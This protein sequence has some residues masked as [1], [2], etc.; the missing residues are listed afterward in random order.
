MNNLQTLI[1][2]G[3]AVV[4][5]GLVL[6]VVLPY[7]K[8]RG[9]DVQ[10][11]LDQSKAVLAAADSAYDIAKPFITESVDTDK[12]DKVVKA[13]KIGMRNVQ[14]L[15]DTGQITNPNERKAAA[16]QYVI[17]SLPLIGVEMTPEIER[18]IDG[19]IEANVY[20]KNKGID[21]L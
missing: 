1:I 4:V 12:F 2:T 11:L 3:G 18:V 13:A 7:L 20:I 15:Y 9:V 10:N 6:G 17:D 16:R 14:Q 21:E 8:R 19:A 5:V